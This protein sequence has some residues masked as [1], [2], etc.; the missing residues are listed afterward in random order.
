M[1]LEGCVADEDTVGVQLFDLIIGQ[2]QQLVQNALVI[3]AEAGRA[4]LTAL[5]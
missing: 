4:Q 1:S 3:L 5:L 2:V